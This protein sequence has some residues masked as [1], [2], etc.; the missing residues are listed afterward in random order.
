M[1]RH[2][3]PAFHRKGISSPFGKFTA[4]FPPFK[5]PEETHRILTELATE[6]E[7]S[8]AEFIREMCIVRAHGEEAVRSVHIH[9]IAVVTGK[10]Q[11]G[12]S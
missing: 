1:A 10:A 9:R 6:N 12:S 7:M 4:K 11:Q 2:D 8:L 3:L 5:G